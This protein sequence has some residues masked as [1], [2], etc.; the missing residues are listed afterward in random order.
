[1]YKLQKADLNNLIVSLAGQYHVLAPVRTDAV[2]F[3][4]VKSADAIDL[5]GNS[6]LPIKQFFFPQQETLFEFAGDKID[7]PLPESEKR[8]FFGVRRCDL[9]AVAHQDRVYLE[10]PQN[11]YYAA[12]RKNTVFVGLHCA[13]PCNQYAFCGSMDLKDHHDLWMAER[14]DYFLVE[15][16]SAEGEGLA[17]QLSSYLKPTDEGPAERTAPGTDKLKTTKIA[18]LYGNPEWES[19]VKWCLSCAAC[20]ST[21]PTCYC[22]EISDTVEASDLTKGQRIRSWSSCQLKEFSRVAGDL[23]FREARSERFRFRIYHQIEYYRERYGVTMCVGCGRCIA[24]CPTRIDW[25]SIVNKM[26]AQ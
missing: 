22:H 25:V 1:M 17:K 5:S 26:V 19:G 24:N 14:G 10:E 12:R 11:P 9:N 21:C 6:Y 2:R 15:A 18:A 3:Q 8:V 16:G 13:Q 23:F 20:T 7:V 4:E